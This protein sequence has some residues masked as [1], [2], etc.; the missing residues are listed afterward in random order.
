MEYLLLLTLPAAFAL[1][2]IVRHR[3]RRRAERARL[4]GIRER[5]AEWL[6]PDFAG[7]DASPDVIELKPPGSKGEP[8]RWSRPGSAGHHRG[9]SA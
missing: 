5:V 8:I 6:T 3:L 7:E 1:V 2:L 9:R 4:A